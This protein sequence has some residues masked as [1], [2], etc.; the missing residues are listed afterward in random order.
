MVPAVLLTISLMWFPVAF[1]FLGM[2]EPKGTGAV[3]AMVGVLTLI[4]A[5]IQAAVFKDPLI[6]ALLFVYG[7]FYN[8]V[9]YAL[10]TGQE[11]LRSTGNVSLTVAIISIIYTILAYTGGPVVEGKTLIAQ[12]NFL[13]LACA[14]Y[15]VL[16]IMVWLNAYGKLPAKILAYSL[17]VWTVV[18]LW[19]PGFW[20]LALGRLPLLG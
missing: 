9:A 6:G 13:A 7:V 14:G 8:S 16:Y 12:S 4:A 10:L 3:T 19:I 15:T 20:L 5:I 2:G 11:D 1:L 18:G 17:I